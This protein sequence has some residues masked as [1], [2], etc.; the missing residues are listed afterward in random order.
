MSRLLESNCVMFRTLVVCWCIGLSGKFCHILQ[1]TFKFINIFQ[2]D[3]TCVQMLVLGSNIFRIIQV[4]IQQEFLANPIEMDQKKKQEFLVL[5]KVLKLSNS[6]N[7]DWKCLK[8]RESWYVVLTLIIQSFNTSLSY[9]FVSCVVL[10][11]N[12]T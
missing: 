9:A 1:K 7:K 2:V 12:Y 5:L 8:M 3:P 6:A 10:E 4:L 11:L